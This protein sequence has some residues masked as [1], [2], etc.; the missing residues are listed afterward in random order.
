M[1]SANDP[2][3][4]ASISK[5]ITALAVLRLKDEGKLDLDRDV[6]AYLGWQ[7]RNPAF[8]EEPITLRLLLSHQSS[9]RDGDD[10]YIVPL[11]QSLRHRLTN[12]IV[13]SSEHGPN[14]RWFAYSNINFPV[15]ASIIE[16]VSG[17]RFDIAM[18][19]LVFKPIKVE[20][21]FNWGA[22]CSA[23]SF[24]KAVVLYRSN[25]D[26]ARDDLRGKPPPCLVV[27][28]G[29]G[30]CDLSG[31][32]P[33]ENGSLFSPHGGL[34]IS[35]M[36]LA[37]IGQ[38]LANSGKP[39]LSKPSFDELTAAQW[40]APSPGDED[41]GGVNEHGKIDGSFC[42]YGLGLQRIGLRQADCNDDLFN[43]GRL[44][45]GHAGEAYGVRSGLWWDPIAKQGIVYFINAVPDD[46]Q[47]CRSTFSAAE[48]A[49]V[50]RSATSD[51]AG[52][53][54]APCRKRE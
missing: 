32:R 10:Q 27:S 35:M 37:R 18:R 9:L 24:R 46:I 2:V 29:D 14:R 34:R 42:S 50:A 11:G 8:P 48:E 5:L 44:R 21:C 25:G 54:N 22:G 49:L 28:T 16:S 52:L 19:R 1:V 38:V 31:Y 20:A 6:S 12:P 4:I 36:Q 41:R 51:G 13:W 3:R 7:L 40:Q 45:L 33:G 23:R 17:E 30:T 39:L 15:V 47:Q 53:S 43:D 26:V